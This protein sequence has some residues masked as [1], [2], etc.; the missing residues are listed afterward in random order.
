MPPKLTDE[1]AR[2]IAHWENKTA[3]ENAK[4]V[5]G[6]LKGFND[7][8]WKLRDKPEVIATRKTHPPG[9]AGSTP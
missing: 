8:Y 1:E 6:L 2:N 9:D 7:H 4:Q 5:A 3:E